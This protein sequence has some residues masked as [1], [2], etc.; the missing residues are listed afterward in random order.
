[1]KI[2]IVIC[3]LWLALFSAAAQSLTET[4][5]EAHAVVPAHV[6]GGG[7]LAARA[8]ANQV[9]DPTAPLTLIQFRDVLAP[10]I[11]GYDSPGNVFQLEPVFPI[12]PSRLL[13][14]EQLVKMTLPMPTTPNP[15]SQTGLGDFQIFDLVSIKQ[16]WGR[17]GI[18]PAL[19]FPTATATALGQGK[20]QAGPAMGAIYTGI[21]N[22]TIGAVAQNPFSFAG[23]ASRPSTSAL[24]ISPTLTYNLPHG[25]FGGFSDFDWSF[26]WKN[27]GAATIPVGLQAGRV[28][29]I[30]KMPVSFSIEGAYLAARPSGT[31]HWI[32]G[33]E[34]TLI[35][36][37]VRKAR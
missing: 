35:F 22:L 12:F 31:P 15:G 7:A 32:F 36:P 17:W 14:F 16:S 23:D 11:P 26:D 20:W 9:N 3:L 4:N 8:L 1:M 30:G 37:T 5:R 25:W 19:T 6:V 10:H 24:T 28:F 27:G 34:F 29:S 18:G 13:P 2:K 33:V 21:H